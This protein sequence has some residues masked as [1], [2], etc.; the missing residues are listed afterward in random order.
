MKGPVV[1]TDWAFGVIAA[2]AMPT[3]ASAIASA[4]TTNTCSVLI[5]AKAERRAA[6]AEM[7]LKLLIKFISLP[8]LF[9]IL[10]ETILPL[11]YNILF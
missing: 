5:P 2:L 8:F 3:A 6:T 9:E 10:P 7:S 11:N 1:L 4:P